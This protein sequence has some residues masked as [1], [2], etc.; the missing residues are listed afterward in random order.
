MA[1]CNLSEK[2]LSVD[3]AIYNI[4]IKHSLYSNILTVKNSVI[5]ANCNACT[6]HNSV[7]DV[8]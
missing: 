6:L 7:K 5:K 8:F 2:E 1:I 3:N 4:G